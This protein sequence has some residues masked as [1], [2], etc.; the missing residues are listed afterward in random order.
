MA[1]DKL[2]SQLTTTPVLGFAN[3]KLAY[4]IHSVSN[5]SLAEVGAALNQVQEKKNQSWP[6]WVGLWLPGSGGG[7][8]QGTHLNFWPSEGPQQQNVMVF[9]LGQ[10]SEHN[11]LPCIL[12]RAGQD[13]ASHRW[14]AAVA[15]YDLD[16][17]NKAGRL[18]CDAGRLSHWLHPSLGMMVRHRSSWKEELIWEQESS[19]GMKKWSEEERNVRTM[20]P[21]DNLDWEEDIILPECEE[22]RVLVG[23]PNL[24]GLYLKTG[25]KK[26]KRCFSLFSYWRV[27]NLFEGEGNN[28]LL[29]K[30]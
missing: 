16:I 15:S 26:L 5:A 21:I 25:W 28:A 12:A 17:S 9:Y 30:R 3:W 6:P 29:L 10:S 18:N 14:P 13:T 11:P 19:Q 4:A 27:G 7:Q 1:F 2:K 22:P 8:W 23:T 20:T 24:Q